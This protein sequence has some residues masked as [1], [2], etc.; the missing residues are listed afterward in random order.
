[1]ILI[2]GGLGFLGGNLGRYLLDL[3]HQVLLTRNRNVQIPDILTP[4]VGKGLQIASMD[5]TLLTTILDAVKKYKVTSIVHGAAI[6]EG[7][8]SLYQAMEVNVM[9]CA[10]I[11]EAARLKGVGRVTFVSSE[12]INQGRKDTTPLKEEEFFWARS[13]RYIPSTK[14]MAELLFFIYQKEYKMDIVITR[15]SRIYGPLYTAGRN[16]IL[17]MV[18]AALK[19][20]QDDFNYPDINETESHDFIYVR[21]CARVMAMIHLAQKP[22]HDIY[23]IGL[24]RLHSYGDVARMLEKIFPGIRIKLGMDVATITKTEYDIVTRLDN[25]RIQEEFGYVPEYD[26]EK[27]LF[28]LAAWLRDGSYL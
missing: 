10:N 12:G 11:L 18:T 25:S 22:R 16:P 2:T 9:G 17:R 23:N 13:D 28:A 15:P 7:K 24:G 1:M 21:D 5:I 27:G 14:K 4:Y 6:Y 3:G 20:G 19:G 8:G 26:L